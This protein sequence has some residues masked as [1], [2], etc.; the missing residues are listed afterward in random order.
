MSGIH[1]NI[2]CIGRGAWPAIIDGYLDAEHLAIRFDRK[3]GTAA[4][5]FLHHGAPIDKCPPEVRMSD[6]PVWLLTDKEELVGVEIRD[7]NNVTEAW[8]IWRA[9]Q[10]DRG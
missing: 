9:R 3:L 10:A 8:T 4:H 2:K 7:G 6:T 1:Y 5:R